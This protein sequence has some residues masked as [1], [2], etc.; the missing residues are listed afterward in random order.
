MIFKRVI[1]S[2][3]LRWADHV[4]RMEGDR[5]AVNILVGKST[6]KRPLGRYR[7]RWKENTRM[8]LKKIG[9]N[10]KNGFIRLRIGTNGEP[11]R[12]WH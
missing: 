5:S 10:L 7:R 1:K 9:I 4:T 6:G 11:L 3:R 2:T 12:I 8:A